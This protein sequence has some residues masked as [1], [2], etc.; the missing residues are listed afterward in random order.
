MM[1][2]KEAPAVAGNGHKGNNG[3]NLTNPDDSSKD[4]ASQGRAKDRGDKFDPVAELRA[5]RSRCSF[6]HHAVLITQLDGILKHDDAAG[7]PRYQIH[8]ASEALEDQPPIEWIIS[9]LF[10]AGSVS[11]AACRRERLPVGANLWYSSD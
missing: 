2:Q 5:I 8:T 7:K 11:L 4:L 10:S 9:D 1:R 6:T 3:D